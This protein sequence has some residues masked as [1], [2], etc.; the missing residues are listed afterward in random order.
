MVKRYSF[1]DRGGGRGNKRR[2]SNDGRGIDRQTN[3]DGGNNNECSVFVGN[4]KYE[5]KWQALK[6]HMRRAGNVDDANIL[7]QPNGRS[8]GCALVK[9]QNP[10]EAQRAIQELNESELEGRKIFVQPDNGHSREPNNNGRSSNSSSQQFVGERNN[11]PQSQHGVYVGNLPYECSWQALKDFFKS[12]GYIDRAEVMEDPNTGKKKGYGV[13][14]FSNERA[15]ENAVRKFNGRD[16][17][18]RT[19]EVRRDKKSLRSAPSGNPNNNSNSPEG[20]KLYFGNL[21][22]DCSWQDLK[23]LVQRRCGRVEHAE[24]HKRGWGVVTFATHRDGAVAISALDKFVFQNRPLE[25]RWDRDSK[26]RDERRNPSSSSSSSSKQLYV[27]NL[28]YDCT[29]QNLKDAFNSCGDVSHAEVCETANGRT[30]GFGIVAYYKPAAAERALQSMDGTDFQGR[31]LS[32]RWDRNPEKLEAQK[33]SNNKHKRDKGNQ[34]EPKIKSATKPNTT[35]NEMETEEK[36]NPLDMAL[37]S[38]R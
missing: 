17:Q 19:L 23:D 30:T 26:G 35:Q 24:I 12:C 22:Y 28:P 29:W 9:Y 14:Y 25:V 33:N 10:R 32:V 11:D 13:V 7:E 1:D 3:N 27:G 18:G 21:D 8:K 2:K 36:G 16:F 20:F 38:S 34:S 5:T 31:K 6:D 4:L 37:S 15:M